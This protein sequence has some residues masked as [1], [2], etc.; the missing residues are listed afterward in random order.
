V[1][2][3][4]D[5][6]PSGEDKRAPVDS[7]TSGANVGQRAPV[8]DLSDTE[9]NTVTMLTELFNHDAVVLYYTMWCPICDSHMSHMRAQVIP[10][11]PN[12]RFLII[13]YVS[14]TVE[15]SRSAQ[16]SNGYTDMTVLVDNIQH[17]LSLY[18]ATMGTTV[19]IENAGDHGIV[20]MNED[21]KDSTKL[22]TT[23]DAL[24]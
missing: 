1:T 16:I 3:C 20:R 14:G 4:D 10:N 22:T 13:D 19:V 7:S 15:L 18:E 8:F 2:A 23:L 9:G 11:Y 24:P 17:V 12:V 5:L 6:Y 21:Y